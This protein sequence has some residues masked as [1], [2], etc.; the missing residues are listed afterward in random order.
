[1]N[2][3]EG[4]EI[5]KD[6]PGYEGNYQV[7]TLG[8]VKSLSRKIK[9]R[10]GFMLSTELILKPTIG[11]KGYEY[12]ALCLNGIC[13]KIKVHQLVAIAFLGHKP[14]GQVLVV[15]HKNFNRLDNRLENLEVI[16]QREN[17]NQKHLKSKSEHVG[18]SFVSASGKWKS[19]I[20]IKET[21]IHLGFFLTEIEASER[22]QQA[23]KDLELGNEIKSKPIP[24]AVTEPIKKPKKKVIA[25]KFPGVT[26][27]KKSKRWVSEIRL[28]RNKKFKKKFKTEIEAYASYKTECEV[29]N[30]V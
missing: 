23:L 8:R 30:F 25:S 6:V 3:L 26:F 27:D 16:T 9:R 18:V 28:S 19:T 11:S 21:Q 10:S 2:H 20:R 15:N 17:S 22:Y 24:K 1:M 4:K 12:L 14:N 7:S 13:K 5:W 29:L